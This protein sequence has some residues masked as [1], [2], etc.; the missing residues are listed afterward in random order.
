[1]NTESYL[2]HLPKELSSNDLIIN[3]LNLFVGIIASD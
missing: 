2:P 3:I 1:M